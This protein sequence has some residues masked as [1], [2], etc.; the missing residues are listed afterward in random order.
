MGLA[1]R[2]WCLNDGFDAEDQAAFVL[3]TDMIF[4]DVGAAVKYAANS[5]KHGALVIPIALEIAIVEE[6]ARWTKINLP[7]GFPKDSS[8]FSGH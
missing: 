3:A 6:F 1:C 2:V 8:R 5:G 4:D 7:E